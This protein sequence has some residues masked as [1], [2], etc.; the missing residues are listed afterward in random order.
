[1]VWLSA[2]GSKARA[3]GATQTEV[4]S[5]FEDFETSTHGDFLGSL[6]IKL[7]GTFAGKHF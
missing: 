5:R 3:R 2:R 7:S 4:A 6:E 1:M